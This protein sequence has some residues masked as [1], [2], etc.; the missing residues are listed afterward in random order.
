MRRRGRRW[1]EPRRAISDE[2]ARGFYLGGA[3]PRATGLPVVLAEDGA[4]ESLP[5]LRRHRLGA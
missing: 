3:A 5:I 4:M 1:Q 2:E